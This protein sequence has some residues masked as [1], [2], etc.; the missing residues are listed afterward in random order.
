MSHEKAWILPAVR[1]AHIVLLKTLP[2]ALYSSPVSVRAV[3]NRSC[4]SLTTATTA[5]QSLERVVS[6]TIIKFKPM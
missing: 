5:D 1:I 6:L 3:P 2:C 4:P